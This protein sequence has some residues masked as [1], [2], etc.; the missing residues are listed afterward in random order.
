MR[1]SFLYKARMSRSA[2]KNAENQLALC[3]ELY[4]GAIEERR[5]AW[6]QRVSIS[7]FTQPAEMPPIKESRPEF[8]AVGSQVLLD[9]L[10]RV[11]LAF[12]GFYRRV[13]IG[14]TPGYPRF[15]S[16][17]RYDSLTFR[18]GSGWKL[19]GKR[20]T[21]QGIG[22]AKLFLS[23]P[24][25]GRIR[26]MTLK[27]DACGDWWVS[28]CCDNV[29]LNPL[30]ETGKSVGID[31]GLNALIAT[32]DGELVANPRPLIA[33]DVK[34][35]RTSRAISRQ[36]K[37]GSNRRKRGKILARQHRR[38]QRVRR[39]FHH[40]T[41]LDLVRRYDLI[42]VEDLNVAGL[43]RGWLARS[44]G[45]AGWSSFTAIL[46]DKAESAGRLIVA[47]NPRGTSQVCS[48]CAIEVR[49]TL[50]VRVHECPACGLSLDRDVNAARNILALATGEAHP[51]ASRTR[52]KV[53]A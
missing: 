46:R 2:I 9:V 53:A 40:K 18:A 39:D 17:R 20:L 5:E 47:V 14:R 48:G 30:A 43:S 6:K 52:S 21:M 35:R 33:A 44:V 29:A 38:V 22:T 32:S 28:F 49:K 36:K 15:K 19:E 8:K 11:D 16:R 45:D 4:N 26:T 31:L 27:R 12:Q 1:R 37:G 10:K 25:E 34:L 3:C 50:A 42:A 51:L 24:I 7:Y 23:R 41:A 13:R